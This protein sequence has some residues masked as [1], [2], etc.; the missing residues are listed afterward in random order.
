M[1]NDRQI[2]MLLNQLSGFPD[3]KEWT[4]EEK[5]ARGFKPTDICGTGG[6]FGVDVP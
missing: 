2:A 4:D 3:A 1:D 6:E 5:I